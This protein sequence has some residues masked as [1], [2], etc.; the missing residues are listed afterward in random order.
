MHWM[1]WY[2]ELKIALFLKMSS[3][4]TIIF[5]INYNIRNKIIVLITVNPY[6]VDLSVHICVHIQIICPKSNIIIFSNAG[7]LY[8]MFFY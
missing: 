6:L 4:E 3:R 8:F 5:M 7:K 2:L 1:G